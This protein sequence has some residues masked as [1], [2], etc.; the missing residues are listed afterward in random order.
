MLSEFIFMNKISKIKVESLKKEI[1]SKLNMYVSL[2]DSIVE[3][4]RNELNIKWKNH[5]V[6]ILIKKNEILYELETEDKKVTTKYV[7]HPKCIFIKINEES[8]FVYDAGT[9]YSNNLEFR[10]IFKLYTKDGIE[11]FRRETIKLENYYQNKETKKIKLHEPNVMENYT[12]SIYLWRKDKNYILK[13]RAKKYVYP[14]KTKAFIDL[15]NSDNFYI[16]YD[17]VD[18]S[19]KEIPNNGEYYGIDSNIV[20]KYFQNEASIEDIITNFNSK[21]YRR[22]HTMY[23]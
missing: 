10:E 1:L 13:R 11:S 12:E 16:R 6:K 5:K 18:S 4:K 2:K 3:Y 9:D 21:K 14:D 19:I 17:K 22:I 8:T 20:F 23:F 15:E 7:E